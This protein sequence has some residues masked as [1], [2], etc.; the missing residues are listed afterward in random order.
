MPDE[1]AER[2]E[3]A[4]VVGVDGSAAAWDALAWA[5]AEAS[6]T[7]RPLRVVYVAEW[8][9]LPDIYPTGYVDRSAALRIV[10]AELVADGARRAREVA[11]NLGVITQMAAGDVAES[12]VRVAA[13]DAM[14]VLGKRRASRRWWRRHRR[15]TAVAVARRAHCPVAVVELMGETGSGDFAGRVVVL[16]DA[17]GDESPVMLF[18][19]GAAMRRGTEVVVLAPGLP[20]PSGVTGAALVVLGV[21]RSERIGRRMS[22]TATL[23]LVAA[24]GPTVIVPG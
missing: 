19:R 15:P 11:P 1:G 21:Q 5:A 18:A 14:I 2:T 6:A 4:I 3:P 9:A 24:I 16:D 17:S 10:G 7:G 13:Q 22:A 12:L 23:A 8:P 20:A